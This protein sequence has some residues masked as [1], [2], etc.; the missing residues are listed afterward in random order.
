MPVGYFD[1]IPRETPRKPLSEIT[2]LNQFGQSFFD[3][4][5]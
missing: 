1:E 3:S 2:Y 4:K 5:K